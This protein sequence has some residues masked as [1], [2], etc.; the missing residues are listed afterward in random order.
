MKYICKDCGWEIINAQWWNIA[1]TYAG[2]YLCD[3]CDM[4]RIMKHNKEEG[5]RV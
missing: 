1:K 3:D 2:E 5:I 4:N